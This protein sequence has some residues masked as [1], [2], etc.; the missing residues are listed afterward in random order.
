MKQVGEVDRQEHVLQK[1]IL[2][3][4]DIVIYKSNLNIINQTQYPSI[5]KAATPLEN[6][7]AQINVSRVFSNACIIAN[8]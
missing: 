3:V 6:S 2:D 7:S 5:A 4:F 8:T 1:V